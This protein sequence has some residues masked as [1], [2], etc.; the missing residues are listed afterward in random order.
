MD[1][2][3]LQILL[4]STFKDGSEPKSDDM[5]VRAMSAR[6][7]HPPAVPPLPPPADILAEATL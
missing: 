7:H 2:V 4:F 5:T 3:T 6:G 1:I